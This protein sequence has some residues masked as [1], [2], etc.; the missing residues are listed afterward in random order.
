MT[1]PVRGV[2]SAAAVDVVVPGAIDDQARPSGGNIYDRRLCQGLTD[3]GWVVR[4]HRLAGS[5]PVP[6]DTDRGLLAAVVAR[7]PRGGLLLVDGLIASAA[8]DEL[9]RCSVLG[10]RLIVLVHLPLGVAAPPESAVATR[11]RAVLA[12]ADV[13]IATS[14]WTGRWLV[15]HYR[16]PSER[17]HVAEPGVASAGLTWPTAAGG[18][19]L[20]VG[21][22]APHKG[23]DL[24]VS[25]LARL[26]EF[27]W[28]CGLVGPEAEPA[29]GRSVRDLIT[30]SGLTERV[31]LTGPLAP[32]ELMARYAETDLVV[33]PS[34]IETYGMVVCEAHARGIPVIAT[35]AGGLPD[36]LGLAGDGSG[37]GLLIPVGDPESLADALRRWLT[38]ETLRSRLRDAAAARRQML[39][40]WSSTVEHIDVILSGLVP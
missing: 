33:V 35:L 17:V 24:L 29:Y 14:R 3:V 9:R 15:D 19:L 38:D 37:P 18:R 2:T 32:A 10:I 34:R 28:R 31:E 1:R 4:E 8:P 25:A 27:D 40:A 36:T 23:Q 12:G 13:L 26:G 11:E 39:P 16:L 30:S 5:W 7:V 22:L 6:N 20:C 21:A